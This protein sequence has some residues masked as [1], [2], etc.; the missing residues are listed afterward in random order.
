MGHGPDYS[1]KRGYGIMSIGPTLIRGALAENIPQKKTVTI[2]FTQAIL[3]KKLYRCNLCKLEWI[4][5]INQNIF[6]Y[7]IEGTN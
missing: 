7:Y 4:V 2:R 6:L 3:F 5:P 1:S